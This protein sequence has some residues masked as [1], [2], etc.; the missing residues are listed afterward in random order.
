MV[1]SNNLDENLIVFGIGNVIHRS[2]DNMC[3][4]Q[5]EN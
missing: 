1:A 5:F 3:V 2:L 4:I